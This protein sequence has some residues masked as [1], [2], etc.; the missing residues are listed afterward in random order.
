MN[1]NGVNSLNFSPETGKLIL[2]TGDGGSG[3]DPFHLA[4]NNLEIAGKIIEIDV[5]QDV[6]IPNPK[7]VTRFN[8]L[9]ESIQ[10]TLTLIAKGVRNIPGISYQRLYNGFMK[11]VGNVGQ[12]MIESI[13][14][15][16][17]YKPIPIIQLVQSHRLNVPLNEEGLINFG[18]RG[19]EGDFPTPVL[20]PCSS[21][22]SINKKTYAF[23]EDAILTSDKRIRPLTNYF[24]QDPRPNKFAG[25]A[26]TGVQ[27][28]IGNQIPLLTSN[29]VFTDLSK[30]QSIPARGVLAYTP[31]KFDGKLSG[32]YEILTDDPFGTQPA[33]F[34]S[35]GSNSDQ[36]RL[37]LGVY[38]SL[39]V[40]DFH[41]GSVYEIVP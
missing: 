12:E 37:F 22:S 32:F 17:Y 8:E 35:L 18:W 24:H 30:K 28:Y 1:H 25:T 38:R 4:Q 39:K 16:G 41:K 7:A 26:L 36:T 20:N 9:P 11:Y 33:Y 21:H 6:N 14:S 40:T 31:V 27:V 23:Y 34:V 10:Q 13:F 5:N 29:V 3:F 19:W 2:T 15:F